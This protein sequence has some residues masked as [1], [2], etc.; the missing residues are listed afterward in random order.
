MKG[1]NR[2]KGNGF[3]LASLHQTCGGCL[4]INCT[5][6]R[7]GMLL[8]EGR[9]VMERRKSQDDKRKVCQASEVRIKQSTW[10]M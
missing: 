10:G 3:S 7:N 4:K 9:T 6:Y 1:I 2:I 8:L 5:E